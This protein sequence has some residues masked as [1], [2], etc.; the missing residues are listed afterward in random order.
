MDMRLVLW[1][2]DVQGRELTRRNCGS[3]RNLAAAC[4][5]VSRRATVAWRKRNAFRKIWTEVNCGPRSTLAASRQVDDPQC[6]NGTRH[7]TR[8]TEAR[9][10]QRCA[11]NLER[12]NEEALTFEEHK[13]QKWHKGRELKTAAMAATRQSGNKGTSHKT[14]TAS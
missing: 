3:R 1:M 5:K 12:A 9:R 6:K 4:R 10:R 14:A 13:M 7:G 8:V 11:E 2:L